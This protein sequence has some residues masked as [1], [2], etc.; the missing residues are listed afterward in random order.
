MQQDL[1]TGNGE[2]SCIAFGAI[3]SGAAECV[4]VRK[5]YSISGRADINGSEETFKVEIAGIGVRQV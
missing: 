3:W 2:I 4:A 1:I 5:C